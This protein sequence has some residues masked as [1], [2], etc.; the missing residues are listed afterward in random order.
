MKKIIFTSL[1]LWSCFV[2]IMAQSSKFVNV[3]I[4]TNGTGHTFPGPS[5]PF[6]M[7]QPG[8]DSNNTDWDYTSGYQYKD[9]T[10]IGFSQTHLS[11]TGIG[12]L[13]DILMLPLFGIKG[14]HIIDKKSEL[15]YPSY[16]KVRKK[17][18]VTVE[19]TCTDRVAMHRYT[20]PSSSASLLVDFQHGIHFQ[21]GSIIL[22][23]RIKIENDSTISGY[24]HTKNWV[25]RR[26]A[27]FIRFNNRFSG[28]ELLKRYSKDNAPKYLF[29]FLL[30]GNHQLLAKIAISTTNTKG[31]RLNMKTEL[32]GWDFDKVRN[33][34]IKDWDNY[35]QRIDIDASEENKTIFYTSL[36]HLLLQPSN[37]ADVD[38]RY[39]G[40]DNKIHRSTTYGYYSTLSNWDIFRGAFP[41]LQILVPERINAIITSMIKHYKYSGILPIWTAWGQDNYCMI[42]NHA[43]PMIVS[44]WKNGFKGFNPKKAFKAMVETSTRS[45]I[46]SQWDISEKYG[47]YPYD[48]VKDESVSKLLENCFDDR[49]LADFASEIDEKDIAENFLDRSRLYKNIFDPSTKLFRGKDSHH[50]WR[51]P[52]N[53]SKAT[54]PLNN[55]G[56]YT[57]ANAWQY[58]WTTSMYDIDS[59]KTL[60]GGEKAFTKHLDNFFMTETEQHDKH[61][62]QEAMIGQYA[63]GNEPCHHITYLYAYTHK[64]W[65]GQSYIHRI[66]RN[67]YKAAPD[68]ILGNDD[69]GQMSAW[70]V[71]SCMGFYPLNPAC[72]LFVT[73]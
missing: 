69:C 54:S 24:C 26:Y 9:T 30:E 67:D 4:G 27:F 17:D 22:D 15:A 40:P 44:A 3:F 36:Y 53:P 42:G 33:S 68:G 16:Y 20:Y 58:F 62:G 2:P 71:F 57:E 50:Q 65:Q 13:G 32:S 46:H 45:H 10:V 29:H 1:I 61:L 39:R 11:G 18:G 43:I 19:L 63:H 25:E 72:G 23:S 21:T 51:R 70:Y 35:L 41:L 6:G 64:P 56:D 38:G 59:V 48:I 49:C 47:Y 28:Y 14:N 66:I 34:A 7:V 73:G 55:P 37:I 8:P 52:F 12:E 5:R 60:L 31:A